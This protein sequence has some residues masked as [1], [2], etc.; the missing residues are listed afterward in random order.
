MKRYFEIAN[1][2]LAIADFAN[3]VIILFTDYLTQKH[4]SP[5]IN[6]LCDNIYNMI[7]ANLKW[8]PRLYTSGGPTSFMSSPDALLVFQNAASQSAKIIDDEDKDKLKKYLE[9]ISRD[10]SV[11]K[12]SESIND[13]VEISINNIRLFFNYIGD[14]SLSEARNIRETSRFPEFIKCS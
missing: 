9:K 3:K 8:S 13:K 14:I 10:I 11:I 6:T 1:D 2:Y 5:E 7:N 12:N 4:K